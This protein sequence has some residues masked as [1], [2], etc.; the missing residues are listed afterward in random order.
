MF[1]SRRH[2]CWQLICVWEPSLSD[3][4]HCQGQQYLGEMR[5]G[6]GAVSVLPA[7][8]VGV[9]EH[10]HSALYSRCP[11]NQLHGRAGSVLILFYL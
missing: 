2:R 10:Y 9:S 4:F 6:R 11:A 1:Y 5:S 3:V 8:P 7:L